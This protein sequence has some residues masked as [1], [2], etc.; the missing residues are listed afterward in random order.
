MVQNPKNVIYVQ[1]VIVKHI[2]VYVLNL[3]IVRHFVIIVLILDL[4]HV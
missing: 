4:M 1:L 2:L 3:K